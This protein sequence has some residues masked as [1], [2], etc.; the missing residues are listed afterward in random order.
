MRNDECQEVESYY[1]KICDVIVT[2]E[3]LAVIEQ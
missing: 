2:V 1:E 3:R